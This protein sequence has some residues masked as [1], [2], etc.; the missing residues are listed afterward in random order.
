MSSPLL[1]IAHETIGPAV[2]VHITG[3]IDLLTA[4]EVHE[5]LE[6]ACGQA[7]P[8]DVVVADLTG[9]TFMGSAAMSVL[10]EINK[11]CRDQRTPLRV[12]AAKPVTVRPL[13]ATGLD[14]VLD[15][16]GSLDSVIRSA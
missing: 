9:V 4:P 1:R 15:V 14:R 3:E 7:K 6:R 13:Q 12:V 8:P 5:S 10:L 2:V 11:Q 16:V